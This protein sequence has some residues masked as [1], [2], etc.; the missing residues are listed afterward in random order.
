[1]RARLFMD[2]LRLGY[3]HELRMPDVRSADGTPLLHPRAYYTLV[4]QPTE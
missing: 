4:R 2:G 1:M 3:V